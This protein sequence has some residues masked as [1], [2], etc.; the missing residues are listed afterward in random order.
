MESPPN[1]QTY[2]RL[3]LLKFFICKFIVTIMFSTCVIFFAFPL[4]V[5][6]TEKYKRMYFWLF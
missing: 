1:K 3:V 6:V 5:M 4:I 2:N